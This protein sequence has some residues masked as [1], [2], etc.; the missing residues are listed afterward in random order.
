MNQKGFYSGISKLM[1]QHQSFVMVTMADVLLS[2]PQELGAK[3]LV[4]QEGLYAGTIGGGKLE[5]AA[6][7][8]SQKMLQVN[9][10]RSCELVRWN[11]KKD[12]GM[13]CGGEVTLLFEPHLSRSWNIVIFGA[14]HVAQAL[15]PLLLTIDCRITCLETRPEW[16]GKL[17]D[18]DRLEK[19]LLPVMQEYVSQIAD[20]SFIISLT[21]GHSYDLPILTEVLSSREFPYVGV[22]GSNSKSIVLRRNLKEH[23]VDD[24]KIASLHCP[25]GLDLGSRDPSEIAVSITAQLLQQRQFISTSI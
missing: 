11:L 1:E 6:I 24:A 15:I 16:L 21:Q 17:P 19:K 25:I 14:G 8:Y 9:Q 4:T 2:A 18:H 23:G 10:P 7:S 13:T 12:I 5:A 20:N 3:I 22:I